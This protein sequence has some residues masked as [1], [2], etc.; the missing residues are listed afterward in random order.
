[1]KLTAKNKQHI[2]DMMNGEPEHTDEFSDGLGICAY[3]H[4]ALC[5]AVGAP[6]DISAGWT[7]HGLQVWCNVHGVNILHVDFEGRQHPGI[8]SRGK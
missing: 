5:I 4:C 6:Q 1:M 2:D 7:L 8:T 3:F